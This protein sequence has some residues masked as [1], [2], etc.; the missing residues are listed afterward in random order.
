[1]AGEY[2]NNAQHNVKL[3]FGVCQSR[4]DFLST[5]GHNVIDIQGEIFC[6]VDRGCHFFKDLIL[7]KKGCQCQK[8]IVA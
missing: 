5:S 2:N 7:C 6:A 3:D 8:Q 4:Q 1:M